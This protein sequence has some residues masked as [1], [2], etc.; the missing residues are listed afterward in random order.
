MCAYRYKGS[1]GLI[2]L[3]LIILQ[4]AIYRQYPHECSNTQCMHA[5]MQIKATANAK[6]LEATKY[7][8]ASVLQ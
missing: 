4:S 5:K 6:R 3:G 7:Y 1:Q 8:N 2:I